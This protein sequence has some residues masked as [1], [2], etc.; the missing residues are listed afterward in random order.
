MLNIGKLRSGS[1]GYYLNSVA[2]GVEDYYLGSGE[3]PGYWIGS[4]INDVGLS[5]EVQERELSLVLRGDDPASGRPFIKKTKAERVPGFDL[6][7]R[8]PKSVSILHALG[9]DEAK[10]DFVEAHE[11]SVAAA[12]GYLE[13]E[14]SSGRRGSGGH[15]SIGS[16]GFIGAAFRHRTSRAG[17]PLLHTHVLVAN[18][19]HGADDKWGAVDGRHLYSHAKTAGY[20]Y[21]AHLRSELTR[22]LG[23]EWGEVRNGSADVVGVSR[24]LIEVF[25]QRRR[26]IEEELEAVNASSARAAQVVTLATR[27]KKDYGVSSESLA[28]EWCERAAAVGV[29]R[30][31]L[32]TTLGRTEPHLVD[33]RE[34][35]EIGQVLVASEGLTSQTSTFTRREALQGFAAALPSG[36]TV[37]EIEELATEF[38][39]SDEV[40]ALTSAPDDGLSSHTSRDRRYSTAEMLSVE[41]GLI[42][43]AVARRDEGAGVVGGEVLEGALRARPS[44]FD[45]Q[46]DMVEALTKS[47]LGV[48]VVIGKAGAGKTFALDAAREA[49]QAS[50]YR[51]LGVALAARAAQELDAGSGIESF[52]LARFL[53][54]VEVE[55]VPARAVIVVDEAGMVGTRDLARL[56]SHAEAARAK[57]VLV[58]DDRQLPE[59]SAGGA[60]RGIRDRL[61]SIEL[62]EVRRQPLGW[63]RDALDLIRRGE[64]DAAIA[65]YR[66]RARVHIGT[67][68]DDTRARLVSDWWGAFRDG[69]EAVMIAARRSEIADL[70]RR[71]HEL[72]RAEGRLG[73]GSLRVGG[74]EFA[75]GDEILTLK[76]APKLGVINGSRGVVADVD[77]Q[78]GAV[79]VTLADGTIV[80]LPVEYL[81]AGDLTHAYAI[82]GHKAQ[83]MTAGRAFVLGDETL[84]KEWAYV[85]MSRGKHENHLYVVAAPDP[86]RE[87]VGG[88]V[89]TVKDPIAE[90]TRAVGRSRAKELAIDVTED[91]PARSG[92][93][94][95]DDLALERALEL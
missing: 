2:R 63:E 28:D 74:L 8:A 1:E 91:L 80:T 27:R 24:E 18:L 39:R 81:E 12:L 92:P 35:E 62:T 95:A 78:R 22:R 70:N 38:L 3:A 25:S 11:A 93:A 37:A 52:T 44:L 53:N 42:E 83:G 40:I 15:R 85:A 17:D 13:R 31:D 10:Q 51:V 14:A 58:G 84:Y 65:A 21:Q 26:E 9:P 86:E 32:V 20:L 87:E 45:D 68:S 69:E 54:D 33:E 77:S 46:R 19:I 23:V 75:P 4:G 30:P 7:F 57:V 60:F 59:I 34:S 56:L 16:K 90:L 61:P 94:A 6:T 5:R 67:S 66:S 48:E 49:W 41:R 36:A 89:E 50:G 73:D 76:N 72:M 43:R 82:T 64:S 55:G 47:G 71:A 88:Q 79:S 29:T